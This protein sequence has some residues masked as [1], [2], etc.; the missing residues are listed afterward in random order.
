MYRQLNEGTI[1][2]A[3]HA[4]RITAEEVGAWW[5]GLEQA[6]R[7][8]TFLAANLGFIVVGRRP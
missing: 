7:A 1:A 6:G 5:D 3:E 2:A 4:G 8:E